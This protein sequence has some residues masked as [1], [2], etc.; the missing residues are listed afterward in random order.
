MEIKNFDKY[1][2]YDEKNKGIKVAVAMSG[3]V[4]SSTV[5]DLK[6]HERK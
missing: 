4:D 5:R 6:Q 1:L 3:G 2:T